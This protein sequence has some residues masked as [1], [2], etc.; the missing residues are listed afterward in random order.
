[1]KRTNLRTL[2]N[3][4][5]R[6]NPKAG[7][8]KSWLTARVGRAIGLAAT[9]EASAAMHAA[10]VER[11]EDRTMLEGS[12][13]TAIAI[14]LDGQGQGN[15]TGQFINPAVTSTD[16]DF[17]SFTP[18]TNDFVTVLADTANEGTSTLNTRITV[19]GSQSFTDVIAT[20]TN[21]GTLTSGLQRDGWAGFVAQANRTYYVVVSSDYS[22]TAPAIPVNN[23]YTLRV[24]AQSTGFDL[25]AE[26][27]IGREL[28]SPVPAPPLVPI[29]PILGDLARRQQ[30][31]VYKY[32]AP[33]GSIFDSVVTVN[34][35]VTQANLTIRL[36]TRLDVYNAAGTLVTSDS[37]AGRLQDG[38][39][40][41]KAAPGETFYIRVRSDKVR[42]D[43]PIPGI[44]GAATGSFFLVFDASAAEAELNPVRRIFSTAGAF[45]GFGDPTVPP[46]PAVPAPTFQT[47]SF[48]FESQGDGLTI[49]TV[50]P[51]GLFPVNDPAVR[52]YDSAG[53]LLAFNDNF[54]GASSQIE[55]RL[56]G[57]R[58]YF[59]VVDGFEVSSLV[60][61]TLDIEA[62]HTFDPTQPLDDH[63]NSV[64][65]PTNPT[66]AERE[67][68]RRQ[69]EQATA[70]IFGNAF[71]TLDAD[72]NIEQD[73]GLRQSAVG[74]GRIQAAGDN[75][76][77][78]F[79]PP[80]DMLSDHEGD[81]DDAGTALFMG[82][83]FNVQDPTSPWPAASRNVTA[84]D[85]NDYWT[86][87]RQFEDPNLGVTWGFND[88]ADTAGTTGAEVYALWDWDPGPLRTAP[89]GF[90]PRILAVGG[91]FDLIVPDPATGLPVVFKNFALWVQDFQTGNF[92][93]VSIGDAD[94]PVRAI[95]QFDNE[96]DE[97]NGVPELPSELYVGGEFQNIGGGAANAL[98]SFSLEFGWNAADVPAAGLVS[99]V[100]ALAVYDAP[101][102]GSGDSGGTPPV[103]DPA[104]PKRLLY[105]GGEFSGQID[106]INV[107][108]LAAWN[109]VALVAP[110]FEAVPGTAI[111]PIFNGP[112][113]AMTT[114][115]F[116]TDPGDPDAR[117][118]M[119]VIG[120]QFTD[121][122]G[123]AVQNLVAFGL[124]PADDAAAADQFVDWIT[125]D[126]PGSVFAMAQWDPPDINFGEIDPLLI[127]GGEFDFLGQ[128][129]LIGFN[130]T[131]APVALFGGTGTNGAV[132]AIN[133]VTDAQEP[134]IEAALDSG[135]VQQVLY[136][137][138]DFTEIDNGGPA[139][140]PASHVAQ[141]SAITGDQIGDD[142]FVWTALN[143]GVAE[144]LDPN[145]P[146]NGTVFA[147]TGF[148]DGNPLRWDRHDR[149]GSR[150]A[151]TVSPASGSFTNM[152]VRVFDSNF[153]V[154]YTFNDTI[155]PNMP[156][157]AGSIDPSL[158]PNTNPPWIGAKLWGGETY[159]IEVSDATGNGTGRY[160]LV[161]TI[162]AYAP[163]LNQDGAR[164]DVNAT[165]TEEPNEGEF[166]R[167]IKI[168]TPLGS[169]DQDN[170]QT[171]ANP[172]G[173]TVTG[174][175]RRIQAIAPSINATINQGSDIGA[176]TSV[177]DTDLYYF[178]AEFTGYAEIRL[179]TFGI[180][181]EF[182][183]FLDQYEEQTKVYNSRFDGAIRIFRNDFTQVA[184]NDDNPAVL[185]EADNIPIGSF[186]DV[187]FFARDSRVVIPVVAGNNYFIQI[188]SGQRWVDGSP[189]LETDRV[190]IIAREQ[191]ARQAIGSYRLL[192]NQMPQLLSDIE[193]GVEKTDDHDGTDLQFAT[194]IPVGDRTSGSL[195]GRA[196]VTGVIDNTPLNPTD[197]D[198]FSLIAPG[199]GTITV[200]VTPQ[201]GSNL[202]PD[203]I[204]VDAFG[205]PLGTITNEGNNIFS[206]TIDAIRG[207][208]IGIGVAGTG[209]SEGAY[210]IDITAPTGSAGVADIDDHASL[211][212]WH[213]ATEITLRDFLGQGSI[214]GNLEAAGDTDVFKIR[215]DDFLSMIATVTSLDP[216]L[217]PFMTV[218]EVSEDPLG[219]PIFLRIGF[220]D[221][222]TANTIN[223]RVIFG[224]APTRIKDVPDP[225]E[226]R[227]YPYYYIVVSGSD[228]QSDFGRYTLNL[229]FPP[230]DDHADGDT[231]LDGAIDVFEFPFATVV[232]VDNTTG[233]ASDTGVLER[234]TDSDLFVFTAPASG[235]ATVTVA[236]ATGSTARL[237]LSIVDASGNVLG[238]TT[239][240]D[241]ATAGLISVSANVT[242]G[243][244]VYIVVQGFEAT[245]GGNVNTTLTGG[246]D[247]SI[248]APPVDDHPNAGEFVLASNIAISN[249]TGAGQLGGTAAGDPLNPRFE[250]SLD[251]DMFSFITLLAGNQTIT[252][253]PFAQS[254]NGLALRL[255]VFDASQ[256]LLTTVTAGA[257][258]QTISF[259]ITGAAV[260][261]RYYILVDNAGV[262]SAATTGEY[263][264]AVTGPVP[265]GPGGGG[266]DPAAIDFNNPTVIS[267]DPRTGD[268]SAN[269]LIN[270]IND[271]DLFAFTP[272]ASGKVF[273]SVI[274]PDGSLLDA[275]VTILDAATETAVVTFNADGTPGAT[276]ATSFNGVA[277]RRYYAIV[278]GLGDSV[279]S[280]QIVVDTKPAL[281]YLYYPEGFTNDN[282]R[283]FISIVNANS[284]D[285]NYTVYLRY[286]FGQLETVIA[287][288]VVRA[289]SRDG[290]TLR[291]GPFY[292]TPG[293]LDNV[294]YS[295]V[296]ESSE[297]IGA[298]LAHYDFNTSLGDSFT[299]TVSPTW[300]MARVER[301][302]G[303][304]LD[305]VVFYNPN[306]FAVDVTLT[307]YK[308]GA[309]VSVT[310]TV[311]ALRRGGL[312]INDMP[313]LPLGVFSV[314]L[315]SKASS[316]G[317]QSAFQGIVTSLSHY[318]T[319]EGYAIGALADPEGGAIRGIVTNITE[320]SKI[321]S[322]L[323][324]FNPGDTPASVSLLGTYVKADL[325]Q[326]ARN[327]QIA[328]KSQVTFTGATLGLI[329]D[330][331]ASVRWT[332]N[333][334]VSALSFQVQNGDADGTQPATKMATG[335]YFGDAFINPV[336]AGNFY[337]ETLYFTNPT[338]LTNNISV[339]LVF[340]DGTTS[341]I[342]LTIAAN[343][344]AELKLHE[345]PEII[346]RNGP[347]WFAVDV[348][349]A[350]PFTATMVHYD[351]FLGGGWATSGVTV[352]IPLDI[353]AST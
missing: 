40:A 155:V 251:S 308:D 323:T 187:R 43:D 57:G 91:D 114:F 339:R 227:A 45:T 325:P 167:A 303:E 212:K 270:E 63:P 297:P 327:F 228:P 343:G 347:Q 179:Q 66:P 56:F 142:E 235:L 341:T 64:A 115:D 90:T 60:Q 350:V 175:T 290:L 82:G 44:A 265:D 27:G 282:I 349:S 198:L 281:S 333:L 337:F 85:A 250:Y 207:Q 108:N 268:G 225:G 201:N 206:V 50:Q 249:T 195:N 321:Q 3:T 352:G 305:F 315:T 278:D 130:A 171:V 182:G 208:Y 163:D 51:T 18:T 221:D 154:V 162:D 229:S 258:L 301:R 125:L 293:I 279:G 283:E 65:L 138:G 274:A 242:R 173:R 287:G 10:S 109:G 304:V 21:N 172:I 219:N 238:F 47:D 118:T 148:D 120:G 273:V 143:G 54:A 46:T 15:S 86:T 196:S 284:V 6:E 160:N 202:L 336:D 19:Y 150:L 189:L 285:V 72:Q 33:A 76:L 168:N 338:A 261:T 52:L 183:E 12:F 232:Q 253:T 95:T 71:P 38:F 59:I 96:V 129:N 319:A 259:T 9:S 322:Q 272:V 203:M 122:D 269:D 170:D 2:F 159:Y 124:P 34:A 69:F 231:D 123:N 181:D 98:A 200:R 313:E 20:G 37:D 83:R 164:D 213:S 342:P 166:A 324:F 191:E 4:L 234:N 89:G 230:T 266:P 26:D 28:G 177:D 99:R 257:P 113:F 300:N 344:S 55:I 277:G 42:T 137:G 317:N 178:R 262:G 185:G 74:T 8:M 5:S 329:T 16:T 58:R 156:D 36:N 174:N 247:L 309:S 199:S 205:N 192:V 243:Q 157:P 70:L 147:L 288:G 126:T 141:F 132:R 220:N 311:G 296:I 280:Y 190:P 78:Q 331:P 239:A 236:R 104:D 94:A 144:D 23:T 48:V 35:Q 161:V 226:D 351:L 140:I 149:A 335:F 186:T 267:L 328:P 17:F 22:G 320:G 292:K 318:N 214:S 244:Q 31:I 62:N 152:L 184:Y 289:N 41:F 222:A 248:S 217:N 131:A 211:S 348:A 216:T 294:P 153:N 204:V 314:Q 67:A 39:L 80:V 139:P 53:N 105:I 302:P 107:Q 233:L 245:P 119:L 180:T 215:S 13:T 176:I 87:G 30:D 276:A 256:N 260:S 136:I 79:V 88:N 252:L 353:I 73:R 345:R 310:R 101:D 263:S 169:G 133:V 346:N 11:L 117:S 295:V 127:V 112:I 194:P 25:G 32:V 61:Y 158:A 188:E 103:A 111:A 299:G 306:N 7:D 1:M 24:D 146:D 135:N 218:Y 151:I 97:D 210:T 145:T 246:F 241:D 312:S 84:W 68:A 332:S 316:P 92:T 307:A 93:W 254:G 326:F 334:Q 193:N 102:P 271:R 223:S 81:N 100:N 197:V 165:Y 29:T 240:P 275:A 121:L 330:Q 291:D 110:V 340:I 14:T 134:G 237:R 77:F 106:G 128:N 255:R 264:V 49:I 209:G 298:T 286:E 116:A 224:V 75:D